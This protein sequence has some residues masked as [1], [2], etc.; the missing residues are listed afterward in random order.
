MKGERRVARARGWQECKEAARKQHQREHE[1]DRK[2]EAARRQT[3]AIPSAKAGPPCKGRN[4]GGVLNSDSP[5][6][7]ETPEGEGGAGAPEGAR[8]PVCSCNF[9]SIV[10]DKLQR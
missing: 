5:L 2:K 7:D 4:D 6:Q 3:A 10:F 9:L 8:Q 1:E